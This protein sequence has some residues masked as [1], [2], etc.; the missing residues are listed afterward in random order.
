MFVLN[1]VIVH[2]EDIHSGWGLSI[3]TYQALSWLYGLNK[4]P[5]HTVGTF[6]IIPFMII[7]QTT[8]AILRS[9]NWRAKKH[10]VFGLSRHECKKF[11]IS[12][13]KMR[14]IIQSL[15]EEWYIKFL[16]LENY[17]QCGPKHRNLFQATESLFKLVATF[18][19]YVKDMNKKIVT[20]CKENP[21]QKLRDLWIDIHGIRVWWKNSKITIS[22]RTGAMM[23]WKTKTSYNLFN[24]I[25]EYLWEDTMYIYKHFIWT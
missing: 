12:E 16:M 24:Y 5:T 9:I 19:S 15:I 2:M 22:K 3:P 17:I 14:M 1:I 23:N 11:W 18:S 7:N 8:K 4:V 25:K 13:H 21:L 20:W 10:Q 6:F